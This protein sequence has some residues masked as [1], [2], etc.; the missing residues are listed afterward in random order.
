MTTKHSSIQIWKRKSTSNLLNQ[1]KDCVKRKNRLSY[2]SKTKHKGHI[3]TTCL[4]RKCIC[5]SAIATTSS[6]SNPLR[7]RV[8]GEKSS[9]QSAQ[10]ESQPL[11]IQRKSTSHIS[12]KDA[13]K[14]RESVNHQSWYTTT[15]FPSHTSF[16]NFPSGKK[17]AKKAKSLDYKS[18]TLEIYVGTFLSPSA[19]KK[20][21]TFPGSLPEFPP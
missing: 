17:G 8:E 10:L 11:V 14:Y 20:D 3:P 15:S 4:S 19:Q 18:N 13:K 16:V 9:T 5:S 2:H 6:V 7:M 1:N 12:C 21:S